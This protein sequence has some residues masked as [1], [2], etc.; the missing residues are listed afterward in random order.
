M[1]VVRGGLRA[2][3]DDRPAIVG[4]PHRVFRRRDDLAGRDP[5]R[6]TEARRERVHV[7]PALGD[8]GRR[9]R[10]DRGDAT[11][12]LLAREREVGVL[13]HLHRDPQRR[14]RAPL[15]DAHLEH[16]ELAVLDGEL[17]VAEVA[18]VPLEEVRVRA[19]LASHLGHAVIQA[20]DRLRVMGPRH[21][22]L[23]LGVEHDVA[24]EDVR[25]GGRVAGEQDAGP[26]VGAPVAEDHRLDGDA[27]AEIL[28]DPLL[29]AVAQGLLAHPRAEDRLDRAAELRPRVRRDLLGAD[30]VAVLRLE[31]RPAVRGE[32]LAPGRLGEA[33]RR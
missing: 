31:P 21:D 13:G 29:P 6:D 4:D 8:V 24:I 19:E 7:G 17:D 20:G 10:E 11:H 28:G 30:D 33:C 9:V 5:G 14:L 2:D 3:E 32:H 18:V 22:V 25:A 15:P 27:R 23:A 16:P 12:G 26:G 1:D